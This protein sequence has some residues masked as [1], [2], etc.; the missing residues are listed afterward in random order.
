MTLTEFV[1][2]AKTWAT[3][4]SVT[5]FTVTVVVK[6]DATFSFDAAVLQGNEAELNLR[7]DS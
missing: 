6:F 2:A 7:V 1:K 5:D 4:N 3:A